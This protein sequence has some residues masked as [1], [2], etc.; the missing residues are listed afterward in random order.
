M[1]GQDCTSNNDKTY[2]L[3]N[4]VRH[5]LDQNVYNPPRTNEIGVIINNDYPDEIRPCDVVLKRLWGTL[6]HL[7]NDNSSYLPL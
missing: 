4:Y 3:R 1:I 5:D 7:T 2:A 6:L